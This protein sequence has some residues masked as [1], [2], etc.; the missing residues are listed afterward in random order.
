MPTKKT[1]SAS[2]STKATPKASKKTTKKTESESYDS[3]SITVLKGLEAVKKRPG[4]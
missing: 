3:S 4:M 1:S 2:K